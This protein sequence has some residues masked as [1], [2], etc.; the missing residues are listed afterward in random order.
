MKIDYGR[1]AH[2]RWEGDLD[3]NGTLSTESG[4]LG[5]Q[6]VSFYARLNH[7]K[8][9]QQ[10]TPE[11]LLAAAHAADFAMVLAVVLAEAG[12]P[13]GA[14]DVDATCAWERL[15]EGGYKLSS[16]H[17]DVRARVPGIGPDELARLVSQANEISP[18]SMALRGNVDLMVE[19]TLESA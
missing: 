7:P 13:P 9:R 12:H 6:P 14:I 8:R 18:L 17:L 5:E 1:S 2:V 4:T 16:M 19:A 11:E 3:G 10:T 15:E